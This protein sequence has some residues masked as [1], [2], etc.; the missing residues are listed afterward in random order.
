MITCRKCRWVGEVDDLSWGA[1]PHC[2]GRGFVDELE[3]WTQR[4]GWGVLLGVLAYIVSRH[5]F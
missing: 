5:A 1:C 4:L 3:R 2:R